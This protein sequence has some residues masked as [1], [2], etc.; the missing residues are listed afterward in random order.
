M[1]V[2]SKSEANSFSYLL[3]TVGKYPIE[4]RLMESIG[5][6]K[7]VSISGSYN[8][9]ST[10]KLMPILGVKKSTGWWIC[11]ADEMEESLNGNNLL[12]EMEGTFLQ[13]PIDIKT[14]KMLVKPDANLERFHLV[15]KQDSLVGQWVR[16]DAKS[17]QLKQLPVGL[18]VS[19]NIA[20]WKHFTENSNAVVT[21]K[22]E[23][24]FEA[25]LELDI[26]WPE[27]TD[28]VSVGLQRFIW[29]TIDVLVCYLC[30]LLLL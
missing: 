3:G 30:V 27:G 25:S 4:M 26:A 12:S 29:E 9:L 15:E 23:S 28:A 10:E 13:F 11:V 18:K 24:T 20:R 7:R 5:L 8:Y 1:D 6:E 14:G 16:F 19:G 2:T 22:D 17:K 21:L